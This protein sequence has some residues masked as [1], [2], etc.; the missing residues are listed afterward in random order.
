MSSAFP[1]QS[2]SRPIRYQNLTY[3]GGA[4]GGASVV[5]TNFQ[6]ATQQIRVFSTLAGWGSIDQLPSATTVTSANMPSGMPI[7]ASTVS[8]EYFTVT[9]G[10]IFT[11]CS[12]T[13]AI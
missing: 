13:P 9:P 4:G 5:S 6:S 12:T 10:Q 2:A 8:G 1:K 3:A 7:P 11:F